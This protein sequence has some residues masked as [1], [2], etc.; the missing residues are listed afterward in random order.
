MRLSAIILMIVGVALIL[1]GPITSVYYGAVLY[2]LDIRDYQL[3]PA[4]APF[5]PWWVH[6]YIIWPFYIPGFVVLIIGIILAIKQR[7]TN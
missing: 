3:Y 7:N 1:L 6:Y 2:Y 4:T 5:A